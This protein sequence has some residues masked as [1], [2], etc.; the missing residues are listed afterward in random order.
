MMCCLNYQVTMQ[1]GN[2]VNMRPIE[3][4]LRSIASFKKNSVLLYGVMIRTVAPPT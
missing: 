2:K 1:A 4:K 3:M